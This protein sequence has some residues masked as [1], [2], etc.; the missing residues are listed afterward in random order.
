MSPQDSAQLLKASLRRATGGAYPSLTDSVIPKILHQVYHNWSDPDN[1]VLTL[2]ADWAAA[3]KSCLSLHPDWEYKLWTVKTSHEFIEDNFPWFLS[4]Y[5]GYK[6]PIQRVD[7]IR[8]FALRHFGGIYIDFDNGCRE[9]LDAITY[10][11]AFTT[12]GGHGT[13]SNNIIGGQPNHP[14]FNLLTESLIVYNWNWILPYIIVSYTS[15]QWFVTAIWELY[16]R[17]LSA[18]GSVHGFEGN[19]WGPLHH[20]LMDTRPD[21][22]DPFVFWTQE[23]GGSW[24]QWDNAWFGWIGSHIYLVIGYESLKNEVLAAADKHPNSIRERITQLLRGVKDLC[25]TEL[26]QDHRVLNIDLWLQQSS[27]DTSIPFKMLQSY[28]ALLRSKLEVQSRKLGIGHLWSRLVTEWMNSS[29]PMSEASD[30]E[31][32]SSDADRQAQRLKALCEKFEEVVFTPLE[33]DETKIE[34]YLQNLFSGD[35]ASKELEW[36]RSLIQRRERS[37]L[38]TVAPFNRE[39]LRWCVNGLLAEDL[40]S[41]EKQDLLREFLKTPVVLD[42]IADVLNVRFADFDNW[43]W[44]AGEQGIPVL[45]RPQ[46]NGK[47]RIWMD[48]DVLQSIFIHYVGISNCVDLKSALSGL[49]S[50]DDGMW[51]WNGGKHLANA[52]RLPESVT[53]IGK[54]RAYANDGNEHEDDEE[55]EKNEKVSEGFNVKQKL[56]RTLATETIVHRTLYGEAAVIQ[57][58]LQWYAT[59]LSHTTIFAVMRFLGYSE[60]LVSF[61]RKV[62]QAP[63]NMVWTPEGSPSGEPR[64]RQRGVPMAHAPEKLTGEM[65]LFIM[66]LAVNKATGMLLYRLHDDLFICGEPS[67][68]AEAW[69]EMG[70]FADVMGVEFNMSKTGSVYITKPEKSRDPEVEATLPTGVV[71]IGH[72][73]LDQE[74]EEWILDQDQ[75]SEHVA[76]LQ[77]QLAACNNILDWVKTWNSCIGRFFSHTLGEPAY[78]FGLK[79]VDSVLQTYQRIQRILFGPSESPQDD[80]D[81]ATAEASVVDYLRSKIEERFGVPDVPDAFIFLPEQLGGLGVKNPFIPYLAYRNRLLESE[82]DSSPDTIMSTYLTSER[83]QYNISRTSFGKLTTTEERLGRL[84]AVYDNDIW[85]EYARLVLD[86]VLRPEEDDDFMSFEEYTRYRESTSQSLGRAYVKL[87]DV[88]NQK[89]ANLEPFVTEALRRA[90]LSESNSPKVLQIQWVLQLYQDELKERWGGPTLVDEKYLPLGLLTMMRRKG[91][92]WTMVL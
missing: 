27:Y 73:L 13:L 47:Y 67:R 53:T 20:I 41:D 66:D 59:G 2:P 16:H 34:Q 60:R 18:D 11:P 37:L 55:K 68:C 78:C 64:I 24:D 3:Q 45:P 70:E 83:A 79:H 51:N 80:G 57:S 71:R 85:F 23:H 72:L 81:H 40:L 19:N 1:A 86:K 88:P 12:D 4:I 63:L 6:F 91:V 43:S 17:L 58:D 42:E 89:G 87:L 35:G 5:D 65:L 15:G 69:K 62:L 10:L 22:P 50:H 61:Y 77:K 84:H 56:L 52:D 33:T 49:L 21:Q 44:E 75:I 74:S 32:E 54:T 90:G 25:E 9:N 14:F 28:E 31:N 76:Q 92:Q 48:E 26:A 46:L 39:V 8:Y 29:T 7:V 36:L 38:S 82:S 30:S